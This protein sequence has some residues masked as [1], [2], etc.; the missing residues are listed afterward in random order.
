MND[1][2]RLR[3]LALFA[4]TLASSLS[5]L[6]RQLLSSLAPTIQKEFALNATEYGYIVAAFSLS[7]ALAAPLAGVLIDRYGLNRMAPLAVAAWSTVGIATGFTTGFVS[8]LLYRAALGVTESGSLPASGKAV[9]LYALPGERALGSAVGQIGISI[10]MVGA[11]LLASFMAVHYGW[12]SAFVAAGLLGFL[13]IPLWLAA[14]R[15]IPPVNPERRGLPGAFGE[16]A[17]DRRT[18]GLIAANVLSMTVYSLW[19]NW[20]TPLLVHTYGL[21]Q[22]QANFRLAWIPPFFAAAGG[23]FGGWLSARFVRSGAAL[24]DARLRTILLAAAALT[25]TALAPSM[26]SG[27]LA[28]AVICWSFF[29]IVALSANTYALPLDFFGVQKAATGVAAL[30]MAY[31]LLQT[32]MSP[33]VGRMVDRFGFAPVCQIIGLMPLAAWL[34]LRATARE[35]ESAAGPDP[36]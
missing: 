5:F 8:L 7:Y 14:S 3:W 27:G 17:R 18:W 2:S 21:S 1:P 28:T 15:A 9:A 20:T 25:A 4:F 6:D 35:K 23:L 11:P 13:W 33:A 26:P 30:T 24:L 32:V 31:G 10:G 36:C 34:V 22:E 12:R 19:M 29:W 16:I